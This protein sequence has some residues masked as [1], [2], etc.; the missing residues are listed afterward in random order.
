ML[1]IAD[2]S[3]ESLDFGDRKKDFQLLYQNVILLLSNIFGSKGLV[4][5]N[6]VMKFY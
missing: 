4:A 6:S 3:G 5:Y 1:G 2:I